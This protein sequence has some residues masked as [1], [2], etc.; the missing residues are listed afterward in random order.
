MHHPW[1]DDNERVGANVH[2][3]QAILPDRLTT[4]EWNRR[5]EP[6]R[7]LYH[8]PGEHELRNIA[9]C[10]NAAV[11]H[12]VDLPGDAIIGPRDRAQQVE[13]PA[14]GIGGPLVAGP[15]D[16]D[17]SFANYPIA[18]ALVTTSCTLLGT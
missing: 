18:R 6:H 8:H 3:A 11:E 10:R 2:I 17:Q 9:G 13:R 5:I 14:E 12:G 16:G 7:F 15:D 1:S 4:E